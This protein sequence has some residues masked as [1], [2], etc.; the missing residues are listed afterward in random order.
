MQSTSNI[1]MYIFA[2]AALQGIL[3]IFVL[4]FSK[5]GNAK[6]NKL[7]ALLIIIPTSV[8]VDRFLTHIDF[9]QTFPHYL[10][11]SYGL[12]FAWAPVFYFYIKVSLYE[13]FEFKTVDLLHLIPIVLYFTING[14]YLLL[15]TSEKIAYIDNFTGEFEL[16]F[17]HIFLPI[18]LRVQILVYLIFSALILFKYKIKELNGLKEKRKNQLYWLK[19]LFVMVFI[20]QLYDMYFITATLSGTINHPSLKNIR[21]LITVILNYAIAFTALKF[22]E[23]IFPQFSNGEK[24]K[25]SKLSED[26]LTRISEE[27]ESLM[28]RE[29]PYL[30]SSLKLID[31]AKKIDISPNYISQALNIKFGLNYSDYINKHRIETAKKLLIDPNTKNYTLL[32]ISGEA[33]FNSKSVFNKAF[34]KHTGKTPTEFINSQ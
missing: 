13:K 31:I 5:K 27:L 29:Q 26:E 23:S 24:Y 2:A 7:L 22:P 21:L 11:I 19:I 18:L 32:H 3:L 10:F 9:Y 15:S 4:L 17:W 25:T 12:W 1:W 30:D 14:E 28:N 20:L 6:A 34:K 33:G 16:T 8:L